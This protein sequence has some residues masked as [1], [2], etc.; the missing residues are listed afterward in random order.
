MSN[1]RHH[2]VDPEAVRAIVAEVL[3]RVLAE[4]PLGEAPAGKARGPGF[5]PAAGGAGQEGVPVPAADA[6]GRHVCPT[7][8]AA[9][10]SLSGGV[11]SLAMVAKLPAGARR[12]T[13][14]T[15]A[16]VTPSARE[17]AG[18]KGIVLERRAAG[19]AR[20]VDGPGRVPFIVA[21]AEC[22][23]DGAA[24]AAG[25]VRAIPG[26]SQLPASGLAEF[27]EAF[28]LHAAR[29]GARGVLLTG[30]PVVATVLANR[31]AAVRAVT[32]RE[33]AGL[34]DAAAECHANL[35]VLDPAR[36]P[37]AAAIRLAK[38]LA[39]RPPGDTPAPLTARPAGCSCKG[40]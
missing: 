21:H 30:R 25:I 8:S 19:G 37:A 14:E 36:F 9:G 38:D 6:G 40:H 10:L 2:A 23:G 28:A 35:L 3:Q 4:R 27:V 39:T 13:I 31:S 34:A 33:P 15:R 17:Y 20:G 16:V 26:G 24:R 7:G 12:V 5:Q 29:D 11:I 18:D 32:G 22:R 1:P